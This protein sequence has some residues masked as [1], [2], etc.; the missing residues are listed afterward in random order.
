MTDPQS[1]FLGLRTVVY[2][3][4]D[5][6]TAKHWYTSVLGMDP[7]FDTNEKQDC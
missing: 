1:T 3:V 4:K 5:L 6:E 7:H 2:Y